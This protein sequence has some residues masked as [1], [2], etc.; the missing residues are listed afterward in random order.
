LDILQ[1]AFMTQFNKLVQN[2]VMDVEADI[3]LLEKTLHLEG[4]L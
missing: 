4:G 1:D 3:G 2:E